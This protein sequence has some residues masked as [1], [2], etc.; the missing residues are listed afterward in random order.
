MLP[1]NSSDISKHQNTVVCNWNLP[2]NGFWI[3]LVLRA[4]I[5]TNQGFVNAKKPLSVIGS[6]RMQRFFGSCSG[7]DNQT[8]DYISPYWGK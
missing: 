6:P 3:N 8:Y 7:G 4:R 5:E 1:L 2:R